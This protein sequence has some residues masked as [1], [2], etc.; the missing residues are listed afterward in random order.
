MKVLKSILPGFILLISIT[1][2]AQRNSG[3]KIGY[4]V[5]WVSTTRGDVYPEFNNEYDL[6]ILTS[7]H[8]GYSWNIKINE[9]YSIQTD[10]LYD[11]KG[12]SYKLMDSYFDEHP[13]NSNQSAGPFEVEEGYLSLPV[14]LNYMISSHFFVE[15]GA[16]YSMGEKEYGGM[17]HELSLVSGIG[18]STKYGDILL[19][20]VHGVTPIEL[21]YLSSNVIYDVDGNPISSTNTSY[22]YTDKNRSLQFSI[23]VPIFKPLKMI[24]RGV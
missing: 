15:L 3:V 5:G 12:Y 13:D 24:K 9:K 22:Q 23:T 20:Y 16:S 10:L 8:F 14:T 7:L 19:R 6:G 11:T 4:N 18:Y 17:I 21:T 2:F 1:I